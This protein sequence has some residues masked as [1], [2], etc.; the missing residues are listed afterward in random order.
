MEGCSWWGDEADVAVHV[1][2]GH[3][4][5][6]VPGDHLGPYRGFAGEGRAEH[7]DG[8][9]EHIDDGPCLAH[10]RF[11]PAGIG[12]VPC[13]QAHRVL[14]AGLGGRGMI[15]DG[16]GVMSADQEIVEDGATPVEMS[17]L[18]VIEACARGAAQEREVTVGDV[19]QLADV[20]PSTASRLVD[21]AE[22]AGLL[23]RIPSSISARRA[24]LELTPAGAALRERAVSA[25]TTWPAE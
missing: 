2:G 23:H 13:D 8:R 21:R 9:A 19:A 3:G 11:Q 17:S 14:G 22:T 15:N 7:I 6:Q 18:L 5:H 25:L 20:A 12:D 4:F 16:D 1:V 10:G 24:A